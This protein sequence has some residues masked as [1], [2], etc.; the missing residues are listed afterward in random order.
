MN[1]K[2]AAINESRFI[3]LHAL[4]LL[5]NYEITFN[6]YKTLNG[7]QEVTFNVIDKITGGKINQLIFFFIE[8]NSLHIESF[9][10]NL[11]KQKDSNGLSAA[12]VYLLMAFYDAHHQKNPFKKITLRA[13]R[14]VANKFWHKLNL[15]L[16]E[17]RPS[18]ISRGYYDF[19]GDFPSESLKQ[20]HRLALT[21][22]KRSKIDYPFFEVNVRRIGN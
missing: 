6:T 20:L 13:E 16:V 19:E 7:K 2:I 10:P 17:K 14:P 5:S 12:L 15:N 22:I 4:K 11:N 21:N 3:I 1:Y 18:P 8:K 9:Y